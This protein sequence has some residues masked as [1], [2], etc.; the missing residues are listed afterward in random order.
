MRFLSALAGAD[1]AG[2]DPEVVPI[3]RPFEFSSLQINLPPAIDKAILGFAS[4]VPDTERAEDGR[5]ERPHITVR[6]RLFT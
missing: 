2:P 5:A 4:N 1:Q 6:Q 3:L